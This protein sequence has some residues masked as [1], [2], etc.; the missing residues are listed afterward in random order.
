MKRN[1]ET[2]GSGDESAPKL[3]SEVYSYFAAMTIDELEALATQGVTAIAA[4]TTRAEGEVAVIK[5]APFFLDCTF[6][7]LAH[8]SREAMRTALDRAERRFGSFAAVLGLDTT[9]EQT[10]ANKINVGSLIDLLLRQE[11]SA[12]EKRQAARMVCELSPQTFETIDRDEQARL[13][14]AVAHF[15]GR[16]GAVEKLARDD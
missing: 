2:S 8:S 13:R 10:S 1:P 6:S 9:I 7:R 12:E 15:E 16:W 14:E 5:L 4:A 11:L 3:P